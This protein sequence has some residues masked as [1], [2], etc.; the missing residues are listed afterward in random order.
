[1]ERGI[2]KFLTFVISYIASK[3]FGKIILKPMY[4]WNPVITGTD[5]QKNLAALP[6]VFFT[7]K[8]MAVLPGGEKKVALITR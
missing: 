8:R 5:R 6:R 1:M 4:K 3:I 7:R 2:R